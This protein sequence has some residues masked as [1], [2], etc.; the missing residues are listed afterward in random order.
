MTEAQLHAA[1]SSG[2]ISKAQVDLLVSELTLQPE[3]TKALFNEILLEDKE[4]TF[5][6][7]W[8]FDHLMRKK[9]VYLLPIFDEFIKGL[10][11]LKSESCIRPLAHVCEM[12]TE[13]YFKK[14][15]PVFVKNVSDDQLEKIM[16]LC[17]DWLISPMNMAPKVFS[18]TSLYY[19]GLKFDWVHL[20]LRLVLEDTF[21]S[22][23]AGYQNRAKKTLDKL[24]KL[25]H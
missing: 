17:F 20:E 6:A 18:M 11:L 5:N 24:A 13:A 12:V 16:T 19:L 9:L 4:G 1:L 15:D 14:K 7:S 22:G 21:A 10:S 8:T 2:R 25:G 23:T 3:L